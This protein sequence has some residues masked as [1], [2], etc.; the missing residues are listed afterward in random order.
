MIVSNPSVLIPEVPTIDVN[1]ARSVAVELS[2]L[3][4]RLG[5]DSPVAMVLRQARRE[6]ASLAQSAAATVVGPFRAAA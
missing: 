1:E 6:V 2:V 4:A 3:I 5:P